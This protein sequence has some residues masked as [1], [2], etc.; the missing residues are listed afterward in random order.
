MVV[1]RSSIPVDMGPRLL[2][3]QD[4]AVIAGFATGGRAGRREQNREGVCS[5][6]RMRMHMED[7]GGPQVRGEA[8]LAAWP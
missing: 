4:R 2:I 6:L 8:M 1:S 3:E 7:C 5:H